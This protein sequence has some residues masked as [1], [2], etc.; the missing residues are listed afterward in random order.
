MRNLKQQL[1]CLLACAA[2]MLLGA[3]P[4]A[5]AAV[6]VVDNSP[7]DHLND[8][9]MGFAFQA[10]DFSLAA[11][12]TVTGIRFWS[13][14]AD[15]T[16]RGSISWA[17]LGNGAGGPGTS[18]LASGTQ[19]IVSRTGTGSYL[20]L[21]EYL[22][23]F[24]LAPLALGTGTYWLVLHNGPNSDLD[25]PNEFLWES[26]A[27]NGTL[28]GAE[29]F[30]VN[31]AWTTNGTEHAFQVLAVPEPAHVLMLLAGLTLAACMQRREQRSD[32]FV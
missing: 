20:G 18:T 23:E 29:R 32:R 11:A 25:D 9:N 14:E 17:I 22:N 3:S 12:T 7:P 5:A 2:C 4:Y 16:Y 28:R 24:A 19:S 26:A 31:G 27:N 15:S 21:N 1:C 13:L 10:E 30:D 8:N 6:V